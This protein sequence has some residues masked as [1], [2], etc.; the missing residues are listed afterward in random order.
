MLFDLPLNSG[1]SASQ[2][3]ETSSLLKPLLYLFSAKAISI[4]VTE[5]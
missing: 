2:D 3:G 5:N 1:G 4:T